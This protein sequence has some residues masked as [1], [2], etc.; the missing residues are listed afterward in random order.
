MTV[1]VIWCYVH[2]FKW[3]LLLCLLTFKTTTLLQNRA[4]WITNQLRSHCLVWS[5]VH[6]EPT[7]LLFKASISEVNTQSGET[8]HKI[9]TSWQR[10]TSK[11]VFF[12]DSTSSEGLHQGPVYDLRIIIELLKAT[13]VPSKNNVWNWKWGNRCSLEKTILVEICSISGRI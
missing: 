9:R 11:I 8:W 12:L 4:I 1:V 6:N 2:K 10:A 3:N 7:H 13:L 5:Q